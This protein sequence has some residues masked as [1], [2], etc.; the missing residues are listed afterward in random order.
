M[1]VNSGP[2]KHGSKRRRSNRRSPGSSDPGNRVRHGANASLYWALAVGLTA[3]ACYVNAVG[4]EFVL[5]DTRLIR[6]NLRIR[7]LAN[8]P[9]LFASSYWDVAGPQALY[10]PLVL[11]SYAVQ[12]AI[13]GLSPAGYT[14]V[15]IALHAAVSILLFSL[16]RAI[17]GSL[18]AAGVAGIAFAVHPVHTE[19]VTGI[20]GRPEL[21]AAFFVLLAVSLSLPDTRRRAPY[22]PLEGLPGGNAWLLRVCAALEG[23]RDHAGPG[24]ASHGCA[25]PRERH[26]TGSQLPVRGLRPSAWSRLSATPG[27]CSRL[28]RRA[29]RRARQHH[30]HRERD[31]SARQPVSADHDDPVR[32]AH[33]RNGRPGV[34]DR[35]CGGGRV[36][37]AAGLAGAAFAGLFVRPDSAR[38]QRAGYPV[39]RGRGAGHGL[40]R[41]CGRALAPQP[42]RGIRAGLPRAD[43]F[44]R[45]QLRHHDRD[46]LCRAPDVSAECGRAHRGSR[47]RGVAD[48]ARGGS[49]APRDRAGCG[50]DRP[51]RSAHL[52]AESGLDQRGH[53]LVGGHQSRAWQCPGPVG[54]RPDSHGTG[55]ERCRGRT[56]GRCGTAL[57]G[58]AVALRGGLEDLPV[59]F[60]G[61]RGPRDDSLASGSIRRGHRTLRTGAAGLAGEF[62]RPDE[63]GLGIVGTRAADRGQGAGAAP[64]GQDCGS[65]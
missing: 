10:R 30:H 49:P 47:G 64:A 55:R 28:S 8:I 43:V 7:S 52:G 5:D 11:V 14:A 36:R 42:G 9:H 62:C 37:P 19:A 25:L 15:N 4:N 39:H 29:S 50:R 21:L 32:R 41:R 24:A 48:R 45:E 27:R 20:S 58:G 17:G 26:A 18:F 3:I 44:D 12:Y 51:R 61:D 16:V 59:V 60:A 2:A 22:W 6:D 38:H 63:L 54:V 65:Q 35:I 33:G 34:H 31:R 23:K 1:T 57:L 46:D 13:H 53:A 56:D 40:H